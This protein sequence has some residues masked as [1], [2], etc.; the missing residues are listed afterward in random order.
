VANVIAE[1]LSAQL[2]EN[3]EQFRIMQEITDHRSDHAAL[4]KEN[5]Y[6]IQKREGIY[7]YCSMM[8]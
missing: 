4:Q 7:K 1:N 6:I 2:D 5:M 8:D 3:G